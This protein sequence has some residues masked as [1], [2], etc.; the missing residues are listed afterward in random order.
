MVKRGQITI[1][2]IA[3]LLLLLMFGFLFVSLQQKGGVQESQLSM[4]ATTEAAVRSYVNTCI[5]KQVKEGITYFGLGEFSGS[6]IADYLNMNLADCA[7]FAIFRQ[8]GISVKTKPVQSKVSISERAVEAKVTFSIVLQTKESR[9]TFEKFDYSLS[10]VAQI[11]EGSSI[12]SAGITGAA[13]ASDDIIKVSTD[14][15]AEL[16]VP[17]GTTYAGSGE[18][19]IEDRKFEAN[20]NEIAVGNKGYSIKEVS[21]DPFAEL[22]IKY[23][24]NDVPKGYNIDTL[25]IARYDEKNDIWVS[26]ASTVDKT[27]KAVTGK[28]KDPGF[29]AIVVN[30][31]PTNQVSQIIFT[32]WLYRGQVYS[33]DKTATII[34]PP[35]DEASKQPTIFA[36]QEHMQLKLSGGTGWNDANARKQTGTPKGKATIKDWDGDDQKKDEGVAPGCDQ[37]CDNCKKLCWDET[38]KQ[39][40]AKG[41]STKRS[42]EQYLNMNTDGIK[43]GTVP[44]CSVKVCGCDENG[45]NC[46]KC[47]DTCKPETVK[48]ATPNNYGYDSVDLVGGTGAPFDYKLQAKGNTCVAPEDTI[49]IDLRT[50]ESGGI[51]NDECKAKLN[52]EDVNADDKPIKKVTLKSG[53]NKLEVDV[54]NKKDAAS[55]ARGHIDLVTG[56]GAYKKCEVGKEL[57]AN[58]L[59]GTTNVNVL[60][61][62]K[63]DEGDYG[64]YE[65]TVREKKFCC[66]D[67]SVADDISKCQKSPCPTE[68][69]K[70]VLEA[71][72]TGCGCGSTVYDYSRDGPGYCCST[73]TCEGAKCTP[74][75]GLASGRKPENDLNPHEYKLEYKAGA[76]SIYMDNKLLKSKQS[77]ERPKFVDFGNPLRPTSAV[78]TW[79]YMKV[80]SVK[81][82][83]GQGKD[84]FAEEFDGSALDSAR[85]VI[86]PGEGT[87][88]L[89]G[90]FMELKSGA[91]NKFPY[92]K[93]SDTAKVFPGTG[94]F[95][96]ILKM[97]YTQVTGH[98]TYFG[99]LPG[100]LSIGQDDS[101]PGGANYGIYRL[102]IVLLGDM[103]YYCGGTGGCGTKTCDPSQQPGQL[104]GNVPPAACSKP[105]KFGVHMML[106]EFD[107]GDYGKQL[108]K[109]KELTGDCGIVKNLVQGVGFNADVDKA[110]AFVQEA[111]KRS[112]IPV[113]R[114]EGKLGGVWEKP[115]PTDNYASIA[116][117]YVDF[118]K[119]VEAKSGLKLNYVEIWNEPNLAEEWGGA[120]DPG[121][122]AQF[123]LAVAK[124]IRDYDMADGKKEINVMNGGLAVIGATSNGNYNTE[125]FINI[126]FTKVPELKDYIDVWSSH[127]YPPDQVKYRDERL[128]L[129]NH[130]SNLPVMITETS[131]GRCAD[132]AC[133]S[134]AQLSTPSQF[135][136]MYRD[137]WYPDSNVVGI[138]PFVLT[139]RDSRWQKFS[140]VD[141]GTLAGNDYY[142]TLKS[143]RESVNPNS[144]AHQK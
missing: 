135:V 20:S 107:V 89:S 90:S 41:W 53:T 96:L 30:C 25:V 36:L 17:K 28:I 33:T 7:D 120:S 47:P 118:I 103:V 127:S 126:M 12:R 115:D 74:G 108:D 13:V 122:Y 111:N 3:G 132:A 29:F 78:G 119:A 134:T 80:D 19:K 77:A 105:N 22:T 72:H 69:D 116:S 86:D 1:F 26:V 16:K 68:K 81:V 64:E 94:D 109:A 117:K 45:E 113:L 6:Q 24:E 91:T 102:R 124:A 55:Y 92:V 65:I 99:A 9:Q 79:T 128:L 141:A 31:K 11:G 76:Y 27:K 125:A 34:K 43:D 10:R 104:P 61:D 32:D 133:S 73:Q 46:H 52:S 144:P 98:G 56:T 93:S 110:A 63:K 140:L 130:G 101:A 83:D 82:V 88:T 51:C 40:D 139:S 142:N 114:L 75:Q 4:D 15:G 84:F 42:K 14:K 23:E 37:D 100:V 112:L 39:Y 8:Q 123:L 50:V 131:W 60:E 59:C 44:E 106:N 57:T 54:I 85:W 18:L 136:G 87:I 70:I 137:I 38:N 21:F 129:V 95:T 49:K 48:L 138:M 97:Q 71:K 2:I 67:N 66:D 62:R 58:C 143:Y 5:D 121:E 35:W